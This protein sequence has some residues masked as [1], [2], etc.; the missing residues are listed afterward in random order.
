MRL[1]R[2]DWVAIAKTLRDAPG[3]TI[4]GKTAVIRALVPLFHYDNPS[5]DER[6][7]RLLANAA[8]ED[9][10]YITRNPLGTNK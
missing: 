10:P 7:F 9:D 6:V 1:K 4:A 5:F 3:L 2:K 8:I